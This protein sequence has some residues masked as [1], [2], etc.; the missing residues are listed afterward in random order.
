MKK[1]LLAVLFCS[2][3]GG[4][5]LPGCPERNPQA[6][7][8]DGEKILQARCTVCHGAGRIERAVHDPATWQQTVDRMMGKSNFG[9]KLTESE[10]QALLEHLATLKK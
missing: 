3:L 6:A 4:L 10:L 9:P 7:E 2:L 1:R 5:V 8:V